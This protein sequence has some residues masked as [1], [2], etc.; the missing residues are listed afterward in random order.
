MQL[1]ERAATM[2]ERIALRL[3]DERI[4]RHSLLEIATLI[5]FI[6]Y[7]VERALAHSADQPGGVTYDVVAVDDV[8]IDLKLGLRSIQELGQTASVPEVRSRVQ[9]TQHTASLLLGLL[10]VRS[11]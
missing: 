5:T 8:L 2:S 7:D 4:S 1:L 11:V 10:G 9:A 6:Q 3:R